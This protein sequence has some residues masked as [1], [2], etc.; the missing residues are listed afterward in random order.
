MQVNIKT[1]R[2]N[3]LF[4][5]FVCCSFVFYILFLFFRDGVSLCNSPGCPGLDF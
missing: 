1:Q 2:P 5:L 4:F 3:L